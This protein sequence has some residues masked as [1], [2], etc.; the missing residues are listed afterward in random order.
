MI[1]ISLS[2]CVSVC[3]CVFSFVARAFRSFF[4]FP[5][6]QLYS[7]PLFCWRAFSSSLLS[8]RG[9]FRLFRARLSSCGDGAPVAPSFTKNGGRSSWPWL[10]LP[11][12]H[13]ERSSPIVFALLF[14]DGFVASEKAFFGGFLP[15][16]RL[17]SWRRA[18][19]GPECCSG[20][21]RR[22]VL[23]R[24][25]VEIWGMEKG[26]GRGIPFVT[27]VQRRYLWFYFR[28]DAQTSSLSSNGSNKVQRCY[29]S[30][31][32]VAV[33]SKITRSGIPNAV[34]ER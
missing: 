4:L 21:A 27:F 14:R 5:F 17:S 26:R 23:H 18:V 25:F 33:R 13:P 20:D 31:Y 16:A 32:N 10:F 28:I 3:V 34:R 7:L 6:F 30:R 19:L 2:V 9:A 15:F 29:S 22:R 11:L 12:F 8:S 1:S 24:C